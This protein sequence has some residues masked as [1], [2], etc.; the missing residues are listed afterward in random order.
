[1]SIVTVGELVRLHADTQAWLR[2]MRVIRSANSPAGD[3]AELLVAIAYGGQLAPKSTKSWDVAVGSTHLQVKSRTVGTPHGRRRG[4][5]PFRDQPIGD[6]LCVFVTLDQGTFE[7]VEGHE[8][9]RDALYLHATPYLGASAARLQTNVDWEILGAIPV[10]G[11]LKK[12]QLLL[13]QMTS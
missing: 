4:F 13:H 8:I 1:M 11:E 7:V 2:A 3:Y 9:R 10:T 5:S 6:L 12:A